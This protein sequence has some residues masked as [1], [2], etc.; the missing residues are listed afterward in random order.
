VPTIQSPDHL[1]QHV[2]RKGDPSAFY[3]LVAPCARA[4]YQALRNSGKNHKET[5]LLLVPFLKSLYRGFS[6]K[7]G[8]EDF[9]SW[10][11]SKQKKHL[12]SEYEPSQNPAEEIFLEGISAADY[13]HLDSQMKL[14]FMRN[15]NRVKTQNRSLTRIW[16]ESALMRWAGGAL[17]FIVACAAAY[18]IITIAHI[19]ITVSITS[20]SFQ[21][22]IQL[23]F[24]RIQQTLHEKSLPASQPLD[25]GVNSD[26]IHHVLPGEK[27]LTDTVRKT[28]EIKKRAFSSPFFQPDLPSAL[29]KKPSASSK[30]SL[31][32]NKPEVLPVV[33][34]K[35]ISSLPAPAMPDTSS[36]PR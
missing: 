5:M 14:L 23:P 2:A 29:V 34:K 4:T 24:L 10:Y 13:S 8:D 6:R 22:S 9:D 27:N 35:R 15:Y 19:R 20:R 26:S 33:Q 31:E 11:R 28:A 36:I 30:D 16:T 7:S 12:G 18:T 32:N 3:T 1:L 17:F 25:K 21:H